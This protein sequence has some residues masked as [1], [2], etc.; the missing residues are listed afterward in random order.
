MEQ[1]RVSAKRSAEDF[2]FTEVQDLLVQLSRSPD[3]ANISLNDLIGFIANIS[4][5]PDRARDMLMHLMKLDG[6]EERLSRKRRRVSEA[7]E[8]ETNPHSVPSSV[9]DNRE[10]D[11]LPPRSS[12]FENQH[13][14]IDE[15][16][17]VSSTDNPLIN[18]TD[19]D[20]DVDLD[21]DFMIVVPE[22]VIKDT[23]RSFLART[24]NNA[25]KVVPCC[26][27][28]RQTH[29]EDL[30]I[31]ESAVLIPNRHYLIP[32]TPHP[33]HTLFNGMLLH[34]EV[35]P[36]ED[37]PVCRE[38]LSKLKNNKR[39]PLALSNNMWIGNIPFE[40]RILTLAE[41]LLIARYFPAAYIIKMYP[42]DPSV[43]YWD[44]NAL[45]SGLKGNVSTY[46]LD[47]AEIAMYV[48][49]PI[50][51]PP[52][53]IY[54]ATIGSKGLRIEISEERLMALPEDGVPNEI[55]V[56]AK[57]SDEIE[58]VYQEH[59]SYVPQ[60]ESGKDTRSQ[61]EDTIDCT[62]EAPSHAISGVLDVMDDDDMDQNDLAGDDGQG[63]MNTSIQFTIF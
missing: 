58:A 10:S 7:T 16:Q 8:N 2:D 54:S 11:T 1:L 63:A 22:D 32:I 17:L 57:Y 51:P 42:R 29:M 59:E 56:I 41:K 37:V 55:R 27:C 50:M 36:G 30:E 48:N 38:C 9:Y 53:S 33:R 46:P 12:P 25:L 15:T 44:P 40:L 4:T 21:P 61:A 26:V 5:Y 24:G 23:M 34:G 62:G 3:A 43:R 31:F 39:P 13:R 18:E 45:N 28:A 14:Q 35:A 49:Q 6:V 47:T 20:V 60:D 52:T 19:V